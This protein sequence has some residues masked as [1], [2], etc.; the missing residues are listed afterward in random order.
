[1]TTDVKQFFAGSKVAVTGAVGTVGREV[2][3][4][5]V[6]LKAAEVRLIDHNES[7]MFFLMERY[8]EDPVKCFLGDVRDR[9]RLPELF[10]GVDVVIHAAAYK[11]VI[12]S[13]YNPFDVIQTNILGVENVVRAATACGVRTV[14][15]T[16][17]DK[18][19]NPTNVMGTSKLMGE[20]LMSAANVRESA[21]GTLFG[22]VRF[23]NVLGSRGSVVPLFLRQ[24]RRGGPVT[25]TDERM[26]RFV[27]TI[28]EAAR[29]ILHSAPICRGGEVFVTKMP[30]IR[31]D[32]LAKVMVELLAPK[33]GH[34]PR[35]VEIRNVGGRPGEKMYE[36]LM[37]DEEVQRSME[38][39][40]VFV[41]KPAFAA[42]YPE[43]VFKYPGTVSD[44]VGRSYVS[45]QE[46]ALDR[47]GLRSYLREHSV[48]EEID[49][50]ISGGA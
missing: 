15:F 29:L 45:A 24:I 38:L 25:L 11:H 30:V 42:I 17:S 20:K 23:G 37:S 48:L 39:E 1:M 36:E 12:L 33:Y 28:R 44:R 32:D 6:D 27:M 10:S 21:A 40:E 47:E 18:A 4:Q 14:L 41:I 19:V 43:R 9:D 22:S 35:K 26:T 50:E 16:S 46:K 2:V 8:R 49:E 34:D 31:I 7:D 13:E 5:L 3:R